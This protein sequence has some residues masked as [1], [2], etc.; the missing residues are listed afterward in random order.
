[1]AAAALCA[2]V[3]LPVAAQVPPP[4]PLPAVDV[5]E[6]GIVGRFH[7]VP[8]THAATAVL[9]LGG[10]EGGLPPARD[11][12]DLARNGHPVLAL[13][14]FKNW[15]GQ[16]AGLPAS[17]TEIPLEYFFRAIDWLKRQPQV[18]PR[19][20][21]I[22]GQSRGAELALLLASLRPDLAG[23]VAFSPSD[24]VWSGLSIFGPRAAGQ[25]PAWTRN[26]VPVPYQQVAET[27]G[28]PMRAG[29]EQAIP[30]PA[31]HIQ[32]ERIT[33]PVLLVSSKADA[34]WPSTVYA[35]AAAAILARR[36]GKVRVENLQFPDASHLLMGTGPG[37]TTLQIPGTSFR[38]AFGGTPEGTAR[39]RAAAWDATKRFLDRL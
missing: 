4:P 19:R 8:G 29:F 9:L 35:D 12:D 5:R 24:R 22:I 16:P 17:L 34:I 11:A 28:A 21:V 6:D 30:D 36:R 7:A 3:A 25:R 13:A 38:I 10:S 20:V 27:Q 14:Y 32:V 31:A 26:G 23:V 39:A 15:Q 33:G 1:M 37:M 18:D 2:L